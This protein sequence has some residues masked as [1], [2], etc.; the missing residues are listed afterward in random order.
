MG[1]GDEGER[2]M[3]IIESSTWRCALVLADP[4]TEGVAEVKQ[5]SVGD[6]EQ[7]IG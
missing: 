2:N 5:A 6:Q 7:D 3:E 4:M 1:V